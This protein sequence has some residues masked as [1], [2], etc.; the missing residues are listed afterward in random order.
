MNYYGYVT[1]ALL[2]AMVKRDS[3][4]IINIGSTAGHEVY[5]KGA[6]YCA[7][8]HAVNVISRGLKMDLL[9]TKVRVS[10]V[11]P[12]ITHTEFYHVR[13]HGDE[14]KAQATFAGMTP[15]S[16]KDIADA[17]IYCATRPAHVNISE[18]IILAT[19]QGS[20]RSVHRRP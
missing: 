17:V 7:T 4:H 18:M 13:F 10:S 16:P 19:D 15:L 11:D 12:G 2:P 9:G 8:K 1:K 6:V 20:A 3:G 14:Q 5:P